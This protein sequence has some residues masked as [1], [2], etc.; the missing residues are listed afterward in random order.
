AFVNTG[1]R[2]QIDLAQVRTALAN[3]NVQLV[4]AQNNYAVSMAQLNQAIGMPADTTYALADSDLPPVPGEGSPPGALVTQALG[5][6]PE[7]AVLAR[8]HDAQEKT[9]RALQGGYGPALTA[10]A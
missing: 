1:I 4:A 6:R 2:P 3:A 7:L 8:Q 9:V 10:N 5:T